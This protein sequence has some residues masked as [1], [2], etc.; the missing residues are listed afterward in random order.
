MP[1]HRRVLGSGSAAATAVLLAAVVWIQS[2]D[3]GGQS[4]AGTAVRFS[5][6]RRMQRV[7]GTELLGLLHPD[8]IDE[9]FF[10]SRIDGGVD[11]AQAGISGVGMLH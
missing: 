1:Q 2:D 5:C 10:V 7:D 4:S 8:V 9:F 6:A 11:P 3:H